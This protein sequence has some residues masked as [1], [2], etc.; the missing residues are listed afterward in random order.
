[1]RTRAGAASNGYS[2]YSILG[3]G[4]RAAR[5]RCSR[6]RA[7][8]AALQHVLH[9]DSAAARRRRQEARA[10]RARRVRLSC[11]IALNC[12]RLVSAPKPLGA[13]HHPSHSATQ[14]ESARAACGRAQRRNAGDAVGDGTALYR[15]SCTVRAHARAYALSRIHVAHA[16]ARTKPAHARAGASLERAGRSAGAAPGTLPC[17]TTRSDLRIVVSTLSSTRMH[18]RYDM[19]E[20]DV[21]VVEQI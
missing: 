19:S 5:L 15:S 13:A 2:R 9:R 6:V 14:Q 16:R 1:M 7:G 8:A 21:F 4:G 17:R 18:R 20:L 3:Q 11:N 10:A 12:Q